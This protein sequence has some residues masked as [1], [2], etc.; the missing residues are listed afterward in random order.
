MKLIAQAIWIGALLAGCALPPI[1]KPKRA[2]TRTAP[3]PSNMVAKEVPSPARPEPFHRTT[4]GQRELEL[5]LIQEANGD[6]EKAREYLE[7]ALRTDDDDWLALAESARL[8]LKC[9]K[10]GDAHR[11]FARAVDEYHRATGLNPSAEARPRVNDIMTFSGLSWLGSNFF[12]TYQKVSGRPRLIIWDRRTAQV[13]TGVQFNEEA[14]EIS[15]ATPSLRVALSD[16]QGDISVYSLL[17]GEWTANV[18]DSYNFGY[19]FRLSP[20]G[21]FLVWCSKTG[22]QLSTVGESEPPREL[23]DA[24]PYTLGEWLFTPDESLAIAASDRQLMSW[25]TKDARRV[26]NTPR[27]SSR[28]L[29]LSQDGRTL[30]IANDT[31][32]VETIDARTGR[33]KEQIHINSAAGAISYVGKGLVLFT[34]DPNQFE[35]W[36]AAE[37]RRRWVRQVCMPTE[38]GFSYRFPFASPDGN[39]L[40][41]VCNSSIE[42]VDSATGETQESLFDWPGQRLPIQISFGQNDVLRIQDYYRA[43][44]WD[45][46]TGKL[47]ASHAVST[48]TLPKMKDWHERQKLAMTKAQ[49]TAQSPLGRWSATI[50]GNEVIVNDAREPTQYKRLNFEAPVTKVLFT[51]EDGLLAVLLGSDGRIALRSAVSGGEKGAL[52]DPERPQD[53]LGASSDG[54]RLLIRHAIG[55]IA[56]LTAPG[57]REICRY[58]EPA[59]NGYTYARRKQAAN[60]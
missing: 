26:L 34:D 11:E 18:S 48:T 25:T 46:R 9:G 2:P 53:L 27:R 51:G 40:A 15:L 47:L 24:D 52:V 58:N 56:V 5:S 57:L 43:R 21:H 23:I 28:G 29:V 36:D 39:R 55:S 32:V 44:S 3:S 22:V 37:K 20:F 12:V 16:L 1:E 42:I 17:T 13:V 7:M 59:E 4:K 33:L 50:D 8:Y 35:F 10:P 41:F 14:A 54:K 38:H 60:G 31:P 6:L 19:C 45:L 49:S 30:A